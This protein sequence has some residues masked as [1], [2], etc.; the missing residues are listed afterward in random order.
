M[1]WAYFSTA[2]FPTASQVMRAD[3]IGHVWPPKGIETF[4]PWHLPCSYLDPVDF[5]HDG[6]LGAPRL[7]PQRS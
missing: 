5:R 6:D 3:F 1:F 7:A 2:L 4:N